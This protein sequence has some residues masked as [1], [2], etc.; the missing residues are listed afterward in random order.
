MT[1]EI[2]TSAPI[3]TIRDF[4]EPGIQPGILLRARDVL[5]H[6]LDRRMA[7]AAGKCGDPMRQRGT[8]TTNGCCRPVAVRRTP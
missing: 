1:R 6:G 2:D 3:R 5:H 4:P 8:D 7:I